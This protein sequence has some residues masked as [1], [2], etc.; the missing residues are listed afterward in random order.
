MPILFARVA[1]ENTAYHF[2]KAFDYLIPEELLE[3]A[4]PGCRVLVP[5]GAGN[6]QRLAMILEV[7][8]EKET[9]NTTKQVVAVLDEAPLLTNEAIQ[10]VFWLKDRYFCT[11]FEAV[12]QLLPAG[13]HYRMKTE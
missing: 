12:K 10:L 4:K 1:V 8:P 2:D 6:A 7:S 5:F 13:I 3:Q 9:Q 11:L